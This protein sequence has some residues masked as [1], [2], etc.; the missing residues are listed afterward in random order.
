MQMSVGGGT[1][2]R[3]TEETVTDFYKSNEDFICIAGFHNC[4]QHHEHT[5]WRICCYQLVGINAEGPNMQKGLEKMKRWVKA[6]ASS[7]LQPVFILRLNGM[8]TDKLLR[9][10]L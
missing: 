8:A 9:I 5:G 4:I 2:S 6:K 3:L 7:D 1:G 10:R